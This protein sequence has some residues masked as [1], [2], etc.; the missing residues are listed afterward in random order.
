M[1][2]SLETYVFTVN[3]GSGVNLCNQIITADLS[4]SIAIRIFDPHFN[5]LTTQ[6]QRAMDVN[7]FTEQFQKSIKIYR[8]IQL[9]TSYF[10]QSHSLVLVTLVITAITGQIVSVVGL[11]REEDNKK[12]DTPTSM[13]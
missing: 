8:E 1:W 10:N 3:Y 7:Q 13:L 5:A 12:L 2:L 6:S 4:L 9:L 11:L